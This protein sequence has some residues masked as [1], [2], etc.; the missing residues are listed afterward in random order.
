MIIVFWGSFLY[1]S[2]IKTLLELDDKEI[3]AHRIMNLGDAYGPRHS[4]LSFRRLS[5]FYNYWT[6]HNGFMKASKI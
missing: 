5:D 2:R 1:L 6:L 4:L 3:L